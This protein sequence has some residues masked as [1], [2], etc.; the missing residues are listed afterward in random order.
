MD[1]ALINNWNSVVSKDDLVFDLG[2]F[3]FAPQSKWKNILSRL[4]GKHY[5]ILGN[6]DLTRWPGDSIMRLFERVENQMVLVIDGRYV[7]LN[8]YP[9]LCYGGVWRN[10]DNAVWQLFGHTHLQKENNSGKDFERLKY[11]FPTQYDVGTDF[12][13]YKPISFSELSE[14]ISFQVENNVNLMYWIKS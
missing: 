13:D 7:Y 9:F 6:H 14:K 12:N 10:V 4:N 5:L 11:A 2:D 3:A 1:D 8:H